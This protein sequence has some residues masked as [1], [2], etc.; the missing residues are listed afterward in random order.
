MARKKAEYTVL[1]E[2]KFQVGVTDEVYAKLSYISK[3]E[4]KARAAIAREAVIN[5][6]R[7]F[8]NRNGRI[9]LPKG[10]DNCW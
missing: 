3:M 5:Y 4:A 8:E 9:T 7:Y 1:V 6:I 2:K 10:E